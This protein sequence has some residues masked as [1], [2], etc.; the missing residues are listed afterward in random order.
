ML[1]GKIILNTTYDLSL[2]QNGG[3]FLLIISNLNYSRDP[4]SSVSP[5]YISLS[6]EF[7]SQFNGNDSSEDQRPSDNSNRCNIPFKNC[8]LTFDSL[9]KSIQELYININYMTTADTDSNGL[10][11]SL[12][13]V[14]KMILPDFDGHLFELNDPYIDATPFE[15]TVNNPSYD[16]CTKFEI[17]IDVTGNFTD[18]GNASASLHGSLKYLNPSFYSGQYGYGGF[19]FDASVDVPNPEGFQIYRDFELYSDL[20]SF[21]FQT[22]SPGNSSLIFDN[23]YPDFLYVFTFG[24]E[25]YSQLGLVE[26]TTQF[27]FGSI[28]FVGNTTFFDPETPY[29]RENSCWNETYYYIGYNGINVYKASFCCVEFE[30]VNTTH[31]PPITTTTIRDCNKIPCPNV[32][33]T[34]STV[35]PCNCY[36]LINDTDFW[37]DNLCYQFQPGSKLTSIDSAFRNSE[38]VGL[39]RNQT[40]ACAKLFIGLESSSDLNGNTI[41]VWNNG[42]PSTYRN[43]KKGYPVNVTNEVNTPDCGVLNQTDGKW[44]NED[45]GVQ[46]CFICE[47]I[48]P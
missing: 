25:G 20:G 23:Q 24:D 10:V 31:I 8:T 12:P 17:K 34:Q 5:S 9:G 27:D 21:Q 19:Q 45:C 4:S 32:N 36:L 40:P 15:S 48:K 38:L 33:W 3:N 35:D 46:R 28:L 11:Y 47:Y 41:W 37:D 22:D 18:T 2:I 14:Q 1:S 26:F 6:T 43:W 44:T 7:L 29:T 30:N 16:R 13:F 42:D 39:A